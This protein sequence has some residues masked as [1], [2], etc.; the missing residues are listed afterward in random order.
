MRQYRVERRPRRA[1]PEKVHFIRELHRLQELA[2][3]NFALELT[4][5][6]ASIWLLCPDNVTAVKNIFAKAKVIVIEGLGQPTS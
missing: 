6:E 2:K 5:L 1:D 3:N 4:D